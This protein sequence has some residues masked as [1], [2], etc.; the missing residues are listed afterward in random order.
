MAARSSTRSRK[1]RTSNRSR[2]KPSA[3]ATTGAARNRRN[4]HPAGENGG[5]GRLQAES[6]E[7]L[8]AIRHAEAAAGADD[9]AFVR[10]LRAR[11]FR[12]TVLSRT[13]TLAMV[14]SN[15][16]GDVSRKIYDDPRFQKNA[17]ELARRTT[18]GLRVMGGTTTLTTEFKDCV[19]VG[20]DSS[21]GCTGTLIAPNLVITAGHCAQVATRVFFGNKVKGAGQVVRVQKVVVHPDY[22]RK[23]RH[24]DL[25][26]LILTKS[27]TGVAPRR[28]ATA[29]LINKA[30]DG[31]A[32]GF[33]NTDAVG[34]YGYGIKRQADIPIASPSCSGEVGG[35]DDNMVYGCDV[36]LEIVAG[37]ALL[38]RDSCTGDSGGPFYVANKK[39]EWLLAGATSR[40]TDSAT[41]TCGD[42]GVYVRVDKYRKWI[43]SA[44]GVKLT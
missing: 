17:R 11:Y 13:G 36:G 6:V 32:V 34:S 23:G 43:E 30:P 19:A 18:G 38:A 41:H 25:M 37:K 28:I 16:G 4:G 14:R 39:G 7:V 10:E 21:W 8:D 1:G 29:A 12:S 5:G 15:T 42:G 3:R 2:S 22:H 26:L 44:S 24:N 9:A 27:V 20:N 31:R 33:G 40:A 35:E